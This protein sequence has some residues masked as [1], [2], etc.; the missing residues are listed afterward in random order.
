M[1][2][3]IS[4]WYYQLPVKF[5]GSGYA[6]PC[7]N[8]VFELTYQCNLNCR[9][10]SFKNEIRHTS[11]QGS[12]FLPLQPGEIIQAL[13]Q[14]PKHS[15]IAFTGGEIL[16][17][18]G[19]MEILEAAAKRHRISLATNG[20]LL[21]DDIAQK[22]VD[23]GVMAI[24]FSLDGTQDIHNA[25]RGDNNAYQKLIAGLESI[26]KKKLNHSYPR[27]GLNGVILKQNFSQLHHNLHLA[28]QLKINTCTFQIFDPSWSRS[29]WRLCDSI[30]TGQKVM[31]QVETIDADWLKE[32]LEEIERKAVE[33][34][35]NVKFMPSLTSA[36]IVDYY[37]QQFNP[38]G[39]KCFLPWSTM[40]ISPYGDVFPCLNFK[41]G[42][43]RQTKPATLWNSYHYRNFR[44]S[45][46]KVNLFESCAGCCKMLRS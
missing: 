1:L 22:L 33:L 13:A 38:A 28:K 6:L 25:I 23:W 35:V 10:C 46:A 42:N 8:A 7:R 36:E 39:W 18:Q 43:I 15:N 32:S 41:I 21:D 27:L 14:F 5:A 12:D 17:K 16:V 24:G 2:R 45:L 9:M 26:N 11:R 37:R 3:H 29:G 19:V 20:T 30:D 44:K 34:N 40:R 31:P 4:R